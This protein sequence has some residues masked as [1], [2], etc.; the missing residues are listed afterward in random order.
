MSKATYWE[1]NKETSYWE[2]SKCGCPNKNIPCNKLAVPY[3]YSGARFCPQCGEPMFKKDNTRR[4]E[5]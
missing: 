3:M 2:C 4:E 5:V 1:Y